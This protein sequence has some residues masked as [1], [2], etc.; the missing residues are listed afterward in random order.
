MMPPGAA[1]LR[2]AV[3]MPCYRVAAQVL[4][5]ISRIGPE[6]AIIYVVDDACPEG[7][8]ELV[9]QACDDPR[10]RVLMHAENGGVGAAVITGYGAALADG[11]DSRQDRGGGR[12]TLL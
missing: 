9:R 5:V 2:V 7:S 4:G 3:V 6:V 1:P 12:W 11:A 10:V 8:G